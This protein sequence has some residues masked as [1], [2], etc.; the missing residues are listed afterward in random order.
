MCDVAT[1]H[2][3]CCL[4]SWVKHIKSTACAT[5]A[6]S[7]LRLQHVLHICWFNVPSR[8]V[9]LFEF[10][11][12]AW[13]SSNIFSTHTENRS[14]QEYGE[15][16]TSFLTYPLCEFPPPVFLFSVPKAFKSL[17]A[18]EKA[19]LGS[20]QERN[21]TLIGGDGGRV[22]AGAKSL[23][24]KKKLFKIE[25][26]KGALILGVCLFPFKLGRFSKGLQSQNTSN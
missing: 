9:Q 3:K 26:L 21:A 25:F 6:L 10:L 1:K 22:R 15:M 23:K 8:W 24:E 11:W 18:Q 13:H 12:R 4:H 7:R 5:K 17:G 2:C 19:G 14:G 16:E 20:R